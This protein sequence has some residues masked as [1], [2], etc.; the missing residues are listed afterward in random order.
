MIKIISKNF[1]LSVQCLNN[2]YNIK[3]S[4]S[5]EVSVNLK[6]GE[7]KQ[8]SNYLLKF[9]NLTKIEIDN[10]TS[11]KAEIHVIQNNNQ[12]QFT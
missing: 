7:E 2:K 3:Q 5:E 1:T 6:K 9:E 10:F 12:L 8:L 11:L 4:F